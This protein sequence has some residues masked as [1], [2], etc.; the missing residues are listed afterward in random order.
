LSIEESHLFA[1]MLAMAQALQG[2]ALIFKQDM[3]KMLK[4]TPPL[5]IH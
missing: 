1:E 4:F 5:S 3:A 2:Q